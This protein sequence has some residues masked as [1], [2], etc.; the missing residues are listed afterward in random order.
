MVDSLYEEVSGAEAGRPGWDLA[1]A[2]SYALALCVHAGT[3]ALLVVAGL[4]LWLDANVVT[5]IVAAVL[6][7]TAFFVAPRF[8][9][10]PRKENVRFRA[11]APA[12]FGLL[13][14]I[15]AEIGARPADAVVVTGAFNASY[16][17]VGLR[18]RR[19]L[20]LGLPLWDT[21]TEQ[22]RIAILGHELAHGVN[23]DSRHG[24][25][26]GTSL[27]TLGRLHHALRPGG[28][29]HR[30][31][32]IVD[33]MARLLQG[34]VS[35]VV[36]L[37]FR[38]QR[39][40]TLRA[41]Q[42]A[43][44]LADDLAARVASPAAAASTLDTLVTTGDSHAAAVRRHA[45]NAQKIEFWDDR[46]QALAELP[47]QERERRRRMAARQRL[48]VDESHPPTHLRIAVL[49]SRPDAE[50]RIRLEPGEPEKIQ[51]ELGPDYARV[52]KELRESARA[53]LYR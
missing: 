37:V 3:L 40:T 41:S 4:L 24:L 28:R 43:E 38:L 39:A 5:I 22:Q 16:G 46:R 25:I 49:R 29:D 34:A 21:L 2:A 11:D 14:R 8:G 50:P 15:G 36:A 30:M 53:A 44:Y 20:E 42:R 23:G 13:D 35:S 32:Y 17:T 1:R 33:L 18:R 51:A 26:V 19:V 48:R 12:L 52:A 31:N 10:L 47:E 45:L 9:R 7:L 27:S 6:L